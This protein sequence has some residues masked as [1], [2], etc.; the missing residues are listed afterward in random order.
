MPALPQRPATPVADFRGYWGHFAG[1]SKML[2]AS[3]RLALRK[4][5]LARFFKAKNNF[6]SERNTEMTKK[7]ADSMTTR[8]IRMPDEQWLLCIEK[9]QE[10]GKESPSD[11]IREAI[12]FYLEWLNLDQKKKFLTPELESVMR[13]TVRDSEERIARLM[14]KNAVELNLLTRLIYHDFAYKPEEVEAIRNEAIRLVSDTN[15]SLNL[16]YIDSV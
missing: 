16:D 12:D 6:H 3:S 14:F 2:R 15:G 1:F 10:L 5:R 8:G 11:F 4:S 7:T 13:A 9:S